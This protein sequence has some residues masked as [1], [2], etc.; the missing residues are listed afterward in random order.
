VPLPRPRAGGRKLGSRNKV[1]GDVKALLAKALS[2]EDFAE[3]IQELW[4][5]K[6]EKTKVKVLELC[7]AYQFGKPVQP[8]VD[9][10]PAPPMEINISAIPFNRERVS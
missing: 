9:E 2:A 6:D 7:L 5:S 3:R 8:V 4:Q 10:E 1:A